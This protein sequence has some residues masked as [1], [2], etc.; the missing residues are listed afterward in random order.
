MLGESPLS[1]SMP[2]SNIGDPEKFEFKTNILSSI[3]SSA[4]LRLT[5][6][7]CTTRF[8]ETVKSESIS[9]LSSVLISFRSFCSHDQV[10]AIKLPFF[11]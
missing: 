3:K 5:V 9:T 10:V 2:A 4:T 7:P 1:I 8:P 6:S 11:L